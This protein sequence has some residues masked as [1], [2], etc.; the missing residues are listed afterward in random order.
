MNIKLSRDIN[1]NK[2]VKLSFPGMGQGF[3]I[4]TNGN[5]PNTHRTGIPDKQEI[6]SYVKLYGTLRQKDII[7]TYLTGQMIDAMV[8]CKDPAINRQ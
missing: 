3:S 1:G 6:I 8:E 5:L 7:D 4:Q 2:I